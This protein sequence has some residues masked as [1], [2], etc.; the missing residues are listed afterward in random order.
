MCIVIN[1]LNLSIGVNLT[2]S[3]KSINNFI[4]YNTQSDKTQPSQ[5]ILLEFKALNRKLST[6]SITE[7]DLKYPNCPF[8]KTFGHK[9]ILN[10][11]VIFN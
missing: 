9:I 8:P 10:C 3:Q 1:S 6:Y 11:N 4:G 5:V 2:R 7:N